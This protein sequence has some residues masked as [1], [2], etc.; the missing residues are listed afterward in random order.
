[1]V[2][3][4][5]PPSTA[6]GGKGLHFETPAPGS[7]FEEVRESERNLQ[8]LKGSPLDEPM[9]KRDYNRTVARLEAITEQL[10]RFDYRHKLEIVD[11]HRNAILQLRALTPDA[12]YTEERIQSEIERRQAIID[13]GEKHLA[14]ARPTAQEAD[15]LRRKIQAHHNAL[16]NAELNLIAQ[17]QN[18]REAFYFADRISKTWA[19]LGFYQK[20]YR[21]RK[22][23]VRRVWFEDVIVTEVDIQLKVAVSSLTLFRNTTQEIPT[24]VDVNRLIEPNVLNML[25]AAC[26][27]QITSP[28]NEGVDF[29]NGTW[30]QVHR[31]DMQDGLF[32]YVPYSEMMEYYPHEERNRFPFPIGIAP[33]RYARFGYLDEIPQMIVAG[34]MGGGKTNLIRSWLSTWIKYHSPDELRIYITDLKRGGDFSYYENIPHLVGD[35]IRDTSPLPK[36]ASDLIRLM[37]QRM[38]AF[39]R[40]GVDNI[41]QYNEISNEKMPRIVFVID[42]AKAVKPMMTSDEYKPLEK[43]LTVLGIQSRAAGI[44]TII[45]SQQLTGDSIV[46]SVK[47]NADLVASARQRTLGASLAISGDGSAKNLVNIQGRMNIY[48]KGEDYTVQT[49]HATAKNLA[50]AARAA[51]NFA[52][53]APIVIDEEEPDLMQPLDEDYIINLALNE[54][55]GEL[56]GVAIYDYLQDIRN[57]AGRDKIYKLISNIKAMETVEYQGKR[58]EVQ[59]AANNVAMLVY[60]FTDETHIQNAESSTETEAVNHNLEVSEEHEEENDHESE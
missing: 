9:S 47:D 54:F 15:E 56:K 59:I 5:R 28:H 25:S 30:L 20:I 35:I 11:D 2:A 14:A 36:L 7:I 26:Q 37:Y 16:E 41:M 38:D 29:S 12:D 52:P 13:K 33:S 57:D 24:G 49:P 6:A 44:H 17:L 23:K 48:Y 45:G 3:N 4:K 10:R 22:T 53:V 34:I 8:I 51:R 50:D 46:K 43:D 27:R 55:E 60:C 18:K 1:M 21:G 31:P 32:K 40:L 42:E 19:S 58:Y 39:N